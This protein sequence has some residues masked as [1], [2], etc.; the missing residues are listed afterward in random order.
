MPVVEA[1]DPGHCRSFKETEDW[2]IVGI[3]AAMIGLCLGHLNLFIKQ[4]LM[5]HQMQVPKIVHA[6]EI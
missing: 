3:V 2:L 6:S 4:P 5:R 1:T